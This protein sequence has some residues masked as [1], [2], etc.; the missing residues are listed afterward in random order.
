MYRIVDSYGKKG[1]EVWVGND[2]FKIRAQFFA[3]SQ[4]RIRRR[5]LPPSFDINKIPELKRTTHYKA[6]QCWFFYTRLEE[7]SIKERK[8]PLQM[9]PSVE[10]NRL[11]EREFR[12]LYYTIYS[13][14]TLYSCF[15]SFF[16]FF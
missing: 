14:M 8:S 7:L 12:I 16:Q 5:E 4:I 2:A 9:Q 13:S 3:E 11:W 1:I 10:E 15:C 6:A